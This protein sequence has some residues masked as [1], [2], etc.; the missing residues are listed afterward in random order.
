MLGVPEDLLREARKRRELAA[1][2]RR[3]APTLSLKADQALMMRHVEELE[4]EAT[5][6]EQQASGN[7]SAPT[8]PK[9]PRSKS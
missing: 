2:L 3:L 7:D 8:D 5:L 9:E 1:D 6:L 4:K